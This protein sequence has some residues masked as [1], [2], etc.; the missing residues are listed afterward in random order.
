MRAALMMTV[1]LALAAG[2]ASAQSGP[3]AG[4]EATARP[5]VADG[6][7]V[8][9]GE[10]PNKAHIWFRAESAHFIAYSDGQHADA[11]ALLKNLER[12]SA[13]LRAF[14]QLDPAIPDGTPK[15]TF[16][17]MTDRRDLHILDP[18][19][20]DHDVGLYQSCEDGVQG[21]A[22]F[23]AFK[24]TDAGPEN[25]P[26]NTG[27]TY[28]FQAY[29][30]HFFYAHF[31]QR[32]PLWYIEGYAEYFS[33]L[34]FD[35]DAAVIGL[36]PHIDGAILSQIDKGRLKA[37]T[38]YTYVLL[39]DDRRHTD[40][41]A[42]RSQEP[43]TPNADDQVGANVR[44]NAGFGATVEDSDQA[45][46]EFR[47]RAWLLTH[48]LLADPARE[49]KLPDYMAAVAAGSSPATAFRKV[50][51]ANPVQLDDRLSRYL[52][53]QLAAV[54]LSLPTVDTDVEF[55]SLSR[56]ADEMELYDAALTGCPPPA[57]GGEML[58]MVRGEAAKYPGDALA[59]TTLA[60]AEI[61]YGDPAK[62]MP[63]LQQAVQADDAGF[64]VWYLLGRAEL[65]TALKAKG[66]DRMTAF[67]AANVTLS[68]AALID[69]GSAVNAFWYYRAHFLSTGALSPDAAGAAILAW[70]TAPEVD[71]YAFH[72][73]LVYA[74]A[75]Q[76]AGAVT[77]L[78][79]IAGNPRPSAWAGP[80]R[81][82]LGRLSRGATPAEIVAGLM[83]VSDPQPGQVEWTQ[84]GGEVL[85]QTEVDDGWQDFLSINKSFD[86][87][88]Q[89]VPGVSVRQADS[90]APQGA[91]QKPASED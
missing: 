16:Y 5:A 77:M 42:M 40:A 29:A 21:A 66:S 27:L 4:P 43:V 31:P 63:W 38:D 30:R 78:T 13:V 61:L 12:F 33:T 49:A 20:G 81:A 65:A 91:E 55:Q 60:R 74:Q 80:A 44:A 26:E 3:P 24:P 22:M 10:K 37:K 15:F 32:T 47:A 25:Q 9:L 18:D 6:T 46:A 1:V 88:G 7:V 35:G 2:H 56:A 36:P 84:A 41:G 53:G 64:D 67:D 34:R 57:Y 58:A 39:D 87:L 8:V 45:A 28:I 83:A 75:G 68:Q 54:R 69:P 90:A 86:N 52:R 17:Y 23:Q 76:T 72:A 73:A 71:A 82:W 59:Q 70:K 19:A 50:F 85:G 11:A 48:W 62:A 89:M 14:S 51:G 79:T